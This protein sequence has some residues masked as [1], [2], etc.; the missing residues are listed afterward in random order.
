M[1]WIKILI[2]L[3]ASLSVILIFDARPIVRRFF[4]SSDRNSA[5]IIVKIAG[6]ILLLVSIILFRVVLK[7]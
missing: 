7:I 3:L 1:I 5:T 2:A 6:A 4:T